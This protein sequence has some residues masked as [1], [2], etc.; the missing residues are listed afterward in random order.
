[1]YMEATMKVIKGL[2]IILLSLFVI[3]VITEHVYA[4]SLVE[5]AKKEKE[6]RAKVAKPG[7][8]INNETIKTY[9]DNKPDAPGTITKPEDSTSTSK[10][11]D[12]V[13]GNSEYKGPT[14]FDGNDESYWRNRIK[15]AQDKIA[16]LEKK[17]DEMQSKI[18]SLQ[19]SFQSMDDPNQRELLNVEIAKTQQDI[20]TAQADLQTAKEELENTR[21]EGRRK[22]AL[23][24]WIY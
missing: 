8:T 19:T 17:A 22:G 5:A 14:D 1:M 13:G 21:E 20:Q 11:K 12:A 15:A 18:N 23:P 16:G 3:G 2:V 9:L 10:S 4:Q 24:G 6:R 7:K